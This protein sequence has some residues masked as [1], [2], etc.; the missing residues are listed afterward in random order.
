MP[1]RTFEMRPFA[2]QSKMGHICISDN[3]FSHKSPV[4]SQSGISFDKFT[5]FSSTP[6]TKESFSVSGYLRQ[7]S[8]SSSKEGFGGAG[9]HGQRTDDGGDDGADGVDDDPPVVVG[10][11]TH[12][13]MNFKVNN[14]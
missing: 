4:F 3:T 10:N 12:S 9:S 1:C 2:P 7:S 5:K 13:Y 11:L 14:I 6:D 8:H